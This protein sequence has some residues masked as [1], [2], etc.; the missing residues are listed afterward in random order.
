MTT[1]GIYNHTV[2]AHL[3]AY[4]AP[5]AGPI[6]KDLEPHHYVISAYDNGLGIAGIPSE[7]PMSNSLDS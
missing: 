5:S 3:R 7:A 2:G 1:P 6:V 4:T